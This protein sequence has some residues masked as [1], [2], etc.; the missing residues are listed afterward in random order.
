VFKRQ[1]NSVDETELPEEQ[2][3]GNGNVEVGD[4]KRGEK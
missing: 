1:G 4:E 3:C 2:R